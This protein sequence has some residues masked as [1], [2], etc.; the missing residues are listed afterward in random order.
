M[1]TNDEK[2]LQRNL[3][4]KTLNYSRMNED[5]LNLIKD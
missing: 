4:N 1:K 3:T 5:S 2:Q